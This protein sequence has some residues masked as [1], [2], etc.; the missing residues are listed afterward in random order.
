MLRIGG[1]GA[2]HDTGLLVVELDGQ[3]DVG[4]SDG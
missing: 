1:G 2:P 3:R 4:D